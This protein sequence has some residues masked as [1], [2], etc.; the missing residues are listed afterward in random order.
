MKYI[1]ALALSLVSFSAMAAVVT[2]DSFQM[3]QGGSPLA[4]L[5]GTVSGATQTNTAVRVVA[6]P[7]T[8]RPG[9]YNTF[10]GADGKFCLTL[11]TYSREVGLS[12]A[13]SP[14]VNAKV[15]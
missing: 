8:S 7:R 13:G 3:V 11:I 4:E 2:V 5:C 14:V 15:K 6:D 10:A 9:V 12:A 1:I